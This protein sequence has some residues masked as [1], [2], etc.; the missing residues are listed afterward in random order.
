MNGGIKLFFSRDEL[1]D[2]WRFLESKITKEDLHRL[3]AFKPEHWKNYEDKEVW[4]EQK[5]VKTRDIGMRVQEVLAIKLKR[6]IYYYFTS[7]YP[8]AY[9]QKLGKMLGVKMKKGEDPNI[10]KEMIV[11]ALRSPNKNT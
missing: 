4:I 5:T 2:I 10:M 6:P 8:K 11:D 3:K 7:T 9:M 1:I